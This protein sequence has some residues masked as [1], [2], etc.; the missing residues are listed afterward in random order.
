MQQLSMIFSSKMISGFSA[1]TCRQHSKKR[2]SAFF[3]MLALW[4]AVTFFLPFSLAYWKAYSATRV[5]AFSV[6]TL[7][8]STTPGTTCGRGKGVSRG[9]RDLS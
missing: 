4:T 2:P 6:M 9:A 1:A 3:M 7:R 5:L 8:D